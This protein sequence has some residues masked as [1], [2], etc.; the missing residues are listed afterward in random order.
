MSH[1]D[2]VTHEGDDGTRRPSLVGEFLE[3]VGH[4]KR[5]WLIPIVVVV[6]A[7]TLLAFVSGTAPKDL[8]Y[9]LF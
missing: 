3:F 7:L 1:Q 8:M 6:A 2:G 5:W 4:N 9:T